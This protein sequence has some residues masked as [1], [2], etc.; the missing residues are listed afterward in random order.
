MSFFKDFKAD[1]AQAV[2]ELIP[3]SEEMTSEFDDEEMV[4][5]FDEDSE[6]EPQQNNSKKKAKFFSA[7]AEGEEEVVKDDDDFEIAPEDLIDDIDDVEAVDASSGVDE[8]IQPQ[9]ANTVPEQTEAIPNPVQAA[10]EQIAEAMQQTPEQVAQTMSEQT[11]PEQNAQIPEEMVEEVPDSAEEVSG[12]ENGV[13]QMSFDFLANAMGTIAAQTES[14]APVSEESVKTEQE[15]E[16]SYFEPETA[17]QTENTEQ[18]DAPVETAMEQTAE[19]ETPTVDFS[20]SDGDMDEDMYVDTFSQP[21]EE[22]PEAEQEEKQEAEPD[23]ESVSESI[24]VPESVDVSE[25]EQPIN[26]MNNIQ[27][28]ESDK[29]NTYKEDIAMLNVA[30]EKPIEDVSVSEEADSATTYITKGTKITG[31]IETDGSVD[32]IGSVEGNVICKGKLVLGGNIQGNV[33]AG[34]IYANAARIEG[35]LTCE[36][37]TKIGVG[38]VIIGKVSGNSAVIAGAVNGDIDVQGPVI[39]DST[40]VIMGNIKSRSV[41]INNGAVIEGFCS[42]CYSEIDVKSFF[43]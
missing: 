14:E 15:V 8:N 5:T 32:I 3:D 26:M 31:D 38:S 6:Q 29:R 28:N 27:K 34:E 18:G 40:A 24:D 9:A 16:S 10:P 12:S 42:Q 13:E 7:F 43:A 20:V 11:A 30:E 1:F 17:L 21:E 19:V 4:N 23:K 2:N 33:T 25:P 41:Q 39:V 37:S 36:G 35:D 22:I